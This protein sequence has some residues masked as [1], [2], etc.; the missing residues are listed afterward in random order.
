[1]TSILSPDCISVRT[2]GDSLCLTRGE[3]VTV[4]Y[5]KCAFNV[6][7]STVMSSSSVYCFI[8]LVESAH[9]AGRIVY[10]RVPAFFSISQ[11]K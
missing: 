5:M 9:Y 2:A 4:E 1:M 7:R 3:Y 8:E 6:C 11:L 10:M